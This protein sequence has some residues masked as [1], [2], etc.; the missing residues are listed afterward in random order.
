MDAINGLRLPPAKPITLAQTDPALN[1]AP[2]S[3]LTARGNV[4]ETATRHV[5]SDQTAARRGLQLP[6]AA[7]TKRVPTA[8]V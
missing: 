3:V 2:T 4:P 8:N 1:H 5:R 6:S 7:I